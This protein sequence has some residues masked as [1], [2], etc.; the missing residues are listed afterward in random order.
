MIIE[1]N[2]TPYDTGDKIKMCSRCGKD[3]FNDPV[4]YRL[5][6]VTVSQASAF[7]VGLWGICYCPY[8]H[9]VDIWQL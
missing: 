1:I 3:M 7:R 8:C 6:N 5:L 2:G 9:K 4:L